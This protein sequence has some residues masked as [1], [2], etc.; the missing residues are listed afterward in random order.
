MN[1]ACT[2]GLWVRADDSSDNRNRRRVLRE[3]DWAAS[4]A[5]RALAENAALAPLREEIRAIVAALE[6]LPDFVTDTMIDNPPELDLLISRARDQIEVVRE[7]ARQALQ[8]PPPAPA[9]RP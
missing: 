1:E 9:P 7:H 3:A 8:S 5:E 4:S 2:I 6:P